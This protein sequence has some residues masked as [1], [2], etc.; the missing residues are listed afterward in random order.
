[1]A[2]LD[3]KRAC[4]RLKKARLQNHLEIQQSATN[5]T[6]SLIP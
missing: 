3:T 4:Q 2:C 1:M 5:L 6:S